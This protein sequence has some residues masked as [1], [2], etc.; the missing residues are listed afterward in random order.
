VLTIAIENEKDF[1]WL[2]RLDGTESINM[3]PG[4]KNAQQLSSTTTWA[5]STLIITTTAIEV[6]DGKPQRVVT[7]RTLKLN[8]DGTLRVE[9]PWG[10]NGVMI[11]SVYA[12]V[13]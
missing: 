2:Y 7:K 6:R 11:G 8:D 1:E 10:G 4:P 5:D 9:A 3:W 12:R 13:K